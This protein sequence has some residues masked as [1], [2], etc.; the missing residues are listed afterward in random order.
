MPEGKRPLG[1]PRCR[2]KDN[3]KLELPSIEWGCGI[4][5]LRKGTDGGPFQHEIS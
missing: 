1:S 2:W 4:I 5:W 3:F